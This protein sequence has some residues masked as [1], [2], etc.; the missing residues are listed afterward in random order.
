MI[1]QDPQRTD[2]GSLCF[3]EFFNGGQGAC[4]YVMYIHTHEMDGIARARGRQRIPPIA[5]PH[6][7][8]PNSISSHEK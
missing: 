5:T 6:H 3:A 4:V 1:N 2:K 8:P 7:R